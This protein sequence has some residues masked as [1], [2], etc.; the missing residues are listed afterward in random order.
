MYWKALR[1]NLKA[2]LI[3]VV[4]SGILAAPLFWQFTSGV[5]SSRFS[6]LSFLADPGPE[7]RLNQLRGE[8]ND[9]EGAAGKLL[10]NKLTAYGPNLLGHYLDHFSTD[11]L[12]INGDSII[13]DK[14]PETGQLYLVGSIFIVFGLLG[15]IKNNFKH[16]KILLLWVSVAPIASSIT[17]QT[18]NAVRSLN[19]VVPL[20]IFMAFGLEQIIYHLSRL[21]Y[22]VFKVFI[23]SLIGLFLFFE[24]IHYLES[25]YVHYP[26]RSPLAWEYGFRDMV[27]KLRKYESEYNKVVITDRYDQPYILVLFYEKYDPAKYQPQAKLTERDKFNFGTVRG[28]DKYEFRQISPEEVK[29]SK[30]VLFIG[31]D[32]ELPKDANII[33][34]VDFPNGEPAFIFVKT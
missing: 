24:V 11:F 8:H 6:G 29:A 12:F 31:T 22:K 28:F 18:P 33:D 34:R 9:L 26:K 19:M 2:A 21:K 14:I 30:G 5:G 15:L 23:L 32:K 27:P 25:Y 10:H 17:F 1:A 16:A 13:R 3:A 7:N 4:I 20:T